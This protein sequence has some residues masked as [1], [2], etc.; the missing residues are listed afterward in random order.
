MCMCLRKTCDRPDRVGSHP[1][2]EALA[3]PANLG[4]GLWTC[5]LVPEQVRGSVWLE[6]DDKLVS[7]CRS[8]AGRCEM[9]ENG[10]T[11]V[12]FRLYFVAIFSAWI[13][14]Y[15]F[16]QQANVQRPNTP[17]LRAA[18]RIPF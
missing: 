10:L 17:R 11:M 13:F 12:T 16:A 8:A 1:K 18:T 7:L 5:R 14:S 6:G 15:F 9:A 2:S 4:L 3:A